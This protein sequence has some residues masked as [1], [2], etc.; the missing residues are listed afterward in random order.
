MAGIV[1][2]VERCVPPVTAA[3]ALGISKATFYRWLQEGADSEDSIL[4]ADPI[5]AEFRESIERAEQQAESYLVNIAMEKARTTADALAILERRFGGVWR[6]KVEVSV[7]VRHIL[8]GLTNDPE[9][10]SAA[11][12]EAERLMRVR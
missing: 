9:E 11:L 1:S 5:K 3:G 6:Q 4:P 2:L 10:L 7:D 8:E 12:A